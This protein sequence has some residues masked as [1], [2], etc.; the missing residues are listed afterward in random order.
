MYPR[1]T[2]LNPFL[3]WATLKNDQVLHL[4]PASIILVKSLLS[5]DFLFCTIG[6]IISNLSFVA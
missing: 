5:L 1:Y 6:I 3:L 4:N 2:L